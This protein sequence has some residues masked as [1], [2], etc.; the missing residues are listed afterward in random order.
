MD[1]PVFWSGGPYGRRQFISKAMHDKSFYTTRLPTD[2]RHYM[3]LRRPT[4]IHG[5]NDMKQPTSMNIGIRI[6]EQD[7]EVYALC[8]I[9]PKIC[10]SALCLIHTTL[11]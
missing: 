10:S 2:G 6:I 4:L 11:I 5:M 3:L 9:Q 8:N 1:V 7:K